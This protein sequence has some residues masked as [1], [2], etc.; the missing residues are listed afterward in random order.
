MKINKKYLITFLILFAVEVLIALFVHDKIIRP[1]IGDVL[2]I[3]L[4][5]TFIRGITQKAIKGLPIYLFLFAVIV[6]VTQYFH[7]VD[8][9]GLR[10]NK[11]LSTIMGTSF[12]IRDVLCYFAGTVIL[13]AWEKIE[14]SRE[15]SA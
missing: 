6:E 14:S 5:Y 10:D 8:M 15:K 7:L 13:V 9:L 1:F 2:V 4:M 3:V 12:D 11:L